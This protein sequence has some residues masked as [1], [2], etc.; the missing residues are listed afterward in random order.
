[1]KFEIDPA[2]GAKPVLFGMERAQV[3][4]ILGTPEST[5]KNYKETVSDNWLESKINVG[6]DF[7]G[8]VNYVGFKPGSYDLIL[9]GNVIWSATKHSDPNPILLKLD[10]NPVERLGFLI[11]NGISITTTG[12][13][14]NDR[15]QQALTVYPAGAYDQHIAK[16]KPANLNQYEK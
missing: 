6:Y 1:M 3:H 5:S 16:A 4:S 14:D 8:T 2:I 15:F 11:F 7:Q 10:P 12:Y 13:H 9:K